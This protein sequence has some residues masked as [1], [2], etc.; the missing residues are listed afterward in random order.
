MNY[1]SKRNGSINWYYRESYPPDIREL[2]ARI[3][4]RAPKGDKWI[5]LETPDRRAAKAELP[6]IRAEQ[7]RKWEEMRKAAAPSG[8]VP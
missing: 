8:K 2:L 5:T 1:L 7:H 3:N 4:G 6:H